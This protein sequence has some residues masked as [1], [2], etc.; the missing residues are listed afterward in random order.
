[1]Q[2]L[3]KDL[4]KNSLTIEDI[5]KILVDLGSE[6]PYM[7]NNEVLIGQTVCHCGTKFKLYYYPDSKIFHCYTDC[8]D[9]FD[10]YELVIRNRRKK[11]ISI[12][13][14]QAV[15]YVANISN[16]LL[17]E[18]KELE[19]IS[20]QKIDD[21][22]WLLKFSG[23]E[24]KFKNPKALNESILEIFCYRPHENWIKDNIGSE[25]MKKFQIGY[26]GEE[27]KIIIPH[28]D[29]EGNLIGVRG[30]ALNKEDVAAGRKYMPI[31]IEGKILKHNV[32]DNLYGLHQNKNAII[33]SGRL[34]LVESEK[35]VLQI[36]T[37]YP[38]YNYT[39]AV[40][41]S[42]ITDHQCEIVKNLGVD[43]CYIAFDKEYSDHKSK[44]ARLYYEK[45]CK[46]ARK[47]TPYMSV[48]LIMDRQGLLQE[49]D[50]PSD[51]G[52]EVFEKLLNDKIEVKGESLDEERLEK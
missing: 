22:D 20:K 5:K 4:I 38:D 11:G 44:K 3:D 39:L 41:G 28:R 7:D 50:S 9:S 34:F 27:N 40:C 31:C 13:F 10:I 15:R 52:K 49:K 17:F 26:W 14:P 33:R 46:L 48:Y 42:N 24:K 16:L 32:G 47:L 37:M 30:R 1:M 8:G 6:P 21:W 29:I 35:S 2:S 51:R 23:E 18:N 36:E 43:R 12:S 45:L 25:A 19:Y